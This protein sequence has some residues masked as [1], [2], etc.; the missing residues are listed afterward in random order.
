MASKKLG[1]RSGLALTTPDLVVLSL[2]SERAMHGY[3]L[4]SELERREVKDWAGISRPQ[5][6][7]SLEKLAK[8]GL[9]RP[10][11][12]KKEPAGPERRVYAPTTDAQQALADALNSDSWARQRPAPPFLTW[13]VL[14]I[15]AKPQAVANVLEHRR[16]F[17]E[18]Q[19]SKEIATL[20]AI[21]SDQGPTI[22]LAAAIVELT[23]R[24][25]TVELEWLRESQSAFGIRPKRP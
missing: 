17:L 6:Y 14:S 8:A 10:V 22:P 12:D 23:I 19:V 13:A 1:K 3:E 21:R 7:Y 4:V 9:V 24:Q 18:A 25:F 11:S 2:L 20:D 16:A 15:H 5:V